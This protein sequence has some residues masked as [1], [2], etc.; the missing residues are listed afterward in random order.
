MDGVNRGRRIVCVGWIESHVKSSDDRALL[1]NL[2]CGARGLLARHGRS[3]ELDLIY[4][5]Y[6]NA[7]RRL[8]N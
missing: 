2:E 6:A 4:Q 7:V 3:D 1:F 8:A 5:A